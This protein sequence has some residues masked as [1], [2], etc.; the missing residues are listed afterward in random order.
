[1]ACAAAG[2]AVMG[3]LAVPAQADSPAI[4]QI[5]L[6]MN[7]PPCGGICV[8]LTVTNPVAGTITLK[9][10]GHTPGSDFVDTGAFKTVTI[11]P[12]QTT[13]DVC[14][15]DVTQLIAG[16]GFNTLRVEFESS[17]ISPLDGTTTK[18]DSFNCT[19]ASPSPSSSPTPSPGV[20]PSPRTSPS[21]G[22][23]PSPR[24]SAS[25]GQSPSPGASPSP[26]SSSSPGGPG[27]P[28]ASSSPGASTSGLASTGG[29]NFIVVLVGLLLLAS[30]LALALVATSRR[31]ASQG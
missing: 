18:S 31:Q 11:V 25:P 24:S 9:V 15:D 17:T 30:G 29:F 19:S 21:P 28:G 7:P 13:Y 1:M 14:F 12:G 3:L 26:G 20:S 10:T 22:T 5:Q 2:A 8:T 27:S 4:T 23:S 6:D 16:Q